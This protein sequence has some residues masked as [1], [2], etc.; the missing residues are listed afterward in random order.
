MHNDLLQHNL[1]SVDR[2]L[3]SA[4]S[5][6]IQKQEEI[7]NMIVDNNQL[8]D[9]VERLLNQNKALENDKNK[10][11]NEKKN[12]K[13]ENDQLKKTAS[14]S[15]SNGTQYEIWAKSGT[16][17]YFYNRDGDRYSKTK[18]Y[19]SDRQKV[20]VFIIRDGYGL[21]ENGWLKMEDLRR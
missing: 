13:A 5:V 8:T 12:L 9:E 20:T 18:K 6:I 3:S 10:L 14:Q 21:T 7:D 19:F 16:K 4:K 11:V 15:S 17:A 1:D 2:E